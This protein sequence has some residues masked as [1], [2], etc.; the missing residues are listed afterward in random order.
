MMG[1]FTLIADF[2]SSLRTDYLIF[3]VVGTAVVLSCLALLIG[4]I[5]HKKKKRKRQALKERS[6]KNKR[7]LDEFLS[8]SGEGVGSSSLAL[9]EEDEIVSNVTA[10]PRLEIEE[11]IKSDEQKTDEIVSCYDEEKIERSEDIEQEFH[12]E[13]ERTEVCEV[14]EPVDVDEVE[15]ADVQA[16]GDVFAFVKDKQNKS[17]TGFAVKILEADDSVKSNYDD[18]ISYALSYKKIKMKRSINSEKAYLEGNLLFMLKIHGKSLRVYYALQISDYDNTTMPVSDESDK[19]SYEK[20][21]VMLKITSPLSVKRAKA[22]IDDVAK[23]FGAEKKK[24]K[25]VETA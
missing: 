24:K 8:S 14:Y 22:L 6:E 21:P 16:L 12:E 11:E 2:F 3:L 25:T 1:I 5:V 9:N 19:K 17:P 4:T 23:R 10:E 18:I 20:T 7:A 15:S 13:I